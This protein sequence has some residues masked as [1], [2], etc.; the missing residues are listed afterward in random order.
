MTDYTWP[1][2]VRIVSGLQWIK[3]LDRRE[4]LNCKVLV[5]F[6]AEKN[7]LGH[8]VGEI[9]GYVEGAV[10]SF[11]LYYREKETFQLLKTEPARLVI[12]NES[13]V[14]ASNIWGFRDDKIKIENYIQL[15]DYVGKLV[16][17]ENEF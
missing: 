16:K 14:I 8:R 6:P 4:R 5:V 7:Q 11:S 15:M 10:C 17:E 1:L 2:E 3:K 9:R 13:Y 12:G